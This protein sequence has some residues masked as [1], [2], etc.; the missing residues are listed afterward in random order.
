[1]ACKSAPNDGVGVQKK[2]VG[3]LPVEKSLGG[4]Q[5]FAKY[6]GAVAE[7][8]EEIKA[9]C[10]RHP[11]DLDQNP[12]AVP[13]DGLPPP[14]QNFLLSAFYIAFDEV[15]PR[16]TDLLEPLIEAK[17]LNFEMSA[18][19]GAPHRKTG[20]VHAFKQGI[21]GYNHRPSPGRATQGRANWLGVSKPPAFHD[22]G[23]NL[24]IVGNRFECVDT[25]GGADTFGEQRGVEADVCANIQTGV[26]RLQEVPHDL[27]F[28][29]R[30]GTTCDHL[31]WD[32]DSPKSVLH[33]GR[34]E[35]ENR[36]F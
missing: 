12:G 9:L 1:M 27:P 15:E 4:Y 18:L 33:F 31:P 13:P 29:L 7:L 10:A 23:E 26:A 24:E 36:N 6:E 32:I 2:V 14:L 3:E 11:R 21:S 19:V 28:A 17:G 34:A 35:S 5:R 8:A 30:E 22:G 25:T 20:A 16:R